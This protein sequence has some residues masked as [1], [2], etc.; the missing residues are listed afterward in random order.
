VNKKNLESNILDAVIEKGEALTSNG[1]YMK[2]IDFYKTQLNNYLE[3]LIIKLASA[4][5]DKY[6]DEKA[7]LGIINKEDLRKAKETFILA[8]KFNSDS[9][10]QGFLL[11]ILQEIDKE[12]EINE[13][14]S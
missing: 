1:E 10:M 12:L 4:Y 8:Q 11:D 14:D 13:G 7:I 3:E 2:A 5:I 6:E 9:T